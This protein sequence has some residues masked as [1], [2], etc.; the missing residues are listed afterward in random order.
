MPHLRHWKDARRVRNDLPRL[1][2]NEAGKVAQL[3]YRDVI[4]VMVAQ[5]LCHELQDLERD[6]VESVTRHTAAPQRLRTRQG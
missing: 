6:V 4:L 5:F 2:V 3:A 1:E